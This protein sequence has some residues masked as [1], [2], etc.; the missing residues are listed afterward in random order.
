MYDLALFLSAQAVE[1][2]LKA[3]LISR[4]GSVPR[5]LQRRKGGH[6]L[7]ELANAAADAS[8]DEPLFSQHAELLANL[9]PM[10]LAGRYPGTDARFGG[11]SMGDFRNW[12]DSFAHRIRELVSYPDN[13]RDDIEMLRNFAVSAPSLPGDYIGQQALRE[14][15]FAFNQSFDGWYITEDN[16]R[17]KRDGSEWPT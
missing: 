15:F 12:L 9:S 5:H 4:L 8:D 2:Y 17:V 3:F 1:L 7:V 10:G 11:G 6:D 16:R 13:C 14:M